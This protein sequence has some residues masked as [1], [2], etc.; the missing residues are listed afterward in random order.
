M[1]S[2]GR[3]PIQIASALWFGSRELTCLSQPWLPH[4]GLLPELSM[5]RDE[6]PSDCGCVGPFSELV[7]RVGTPRSLHQPAMLL[8]MSPS[9]ES[10]VT[11]AVILL[12][13][14]GSQHHG[15]VGHWPDQPEGI[16]KMQET[17]LQPPSGL[18]EWL[19]IL[20]AGLSWTGHPAPKRSLR[21]G[22]M[23]LHQTA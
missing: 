12:L 4:G 9:A 1:V 7:G 18:G 16:C 10:S 6:F 23:S 15:S 13:T 8:Q 21:L 19:H 3:L 2:P 20:S 17:I 14:S 5:F 11:T 22:K